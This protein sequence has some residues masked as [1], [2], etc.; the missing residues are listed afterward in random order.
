MS[1]DVSEIHTIEF[2][3]KKGGFV[4][5]GA[6]ADFDDDRFFVVGVLRGEEVGKFLIDATKFV[7]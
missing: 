1:F 6:S 4:A 5:A 3:G 2:G 7:F